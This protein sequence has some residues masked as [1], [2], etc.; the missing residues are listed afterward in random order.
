MSN[1][2]K[3]LND[4]LLFYTEYFAIHTMYKY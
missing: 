3:Y 2:K 1:L 4:L